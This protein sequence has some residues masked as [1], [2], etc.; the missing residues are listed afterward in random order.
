MMITPP[1]GL[2]ARPRNRQLQHLSSYIN[3]HLAREER[4]GEDTASRRDSEE[5]TEMRLDFQSVY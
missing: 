3:R 1:Y 4:R 5:S 2:E